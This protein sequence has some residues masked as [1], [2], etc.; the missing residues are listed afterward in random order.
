[1]AVEA[2]S[3]CQT[4]RKRCKSAVG[5]CCVSCSHVF[6]EDAKPYVARYRLLSLVSTEN[7]VRLFGSLVDPYRRLTPA[8][9]TLAE[10]LMKAAS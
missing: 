6:A 4:A 7:L 2:C 1:M 8:E 5:R 3:S 9:K 10:H